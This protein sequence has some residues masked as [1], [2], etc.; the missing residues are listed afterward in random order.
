MNGHARFFSW[1]RFRVFRGCW[2]RRHFFTVDALS[3]LLHNFV[4]LMPTIGERWI[5]FFLVTKKKEFARESL[6]KNLHQR[7]HNSTP[8]RG[9]DIQVSALYRKS[10]G[11]RFR[12]QDTE[13]RSFLR[14]IEFAMKARGLVHTNGGA[15]IDNIAFF[16]QSTLA[17][18][19]PFTRRTNWRHCN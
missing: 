3:F 15:K 13:R 12:F 1:W 2:L 4:T 6:G 8:F 18:C 9:N 10:V 14:D 11:G 19:R 17:A 16:P 7:P 5:E